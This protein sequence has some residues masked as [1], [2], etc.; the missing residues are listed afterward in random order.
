MAD[1]NV[2]VVALEKNKIK[3]A[4]RT[5]FILSAEIFVI[6]LGT[7]QV[8]FFATQVTV[9]PLLALAINVGVYGLVAV[10]VKHR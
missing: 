5:D 10:I 3:G 4:I 9:V 7:V 8:K 1:P 2:D 6:V